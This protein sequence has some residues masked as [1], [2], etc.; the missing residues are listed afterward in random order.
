MNFS[1]QRDFVIQ[2]QSDA[3]GTVIKAVSSSSK[4]R[5]LDNEPKATQYIYQAVVKVHTSDPLI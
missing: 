5:Y 3:I 2:V 1:S 4:Y